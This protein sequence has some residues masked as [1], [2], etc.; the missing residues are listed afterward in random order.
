MPPT[1]G[2]FGGIPC[3]PRVSEGDTKSDRFATSMPW[4]GAKVQGFAG[5]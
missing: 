3:N 2:G 1:R 4:Y 5:E